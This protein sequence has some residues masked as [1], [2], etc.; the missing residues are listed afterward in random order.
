MNS[1]YNKC[2][3]FPNLYSCL[4]YLYPSNPIRTQTIYMP[5]SLCVGAFVLL[6]KA[7]NAIMYT[8]NKKLASWRFVDNRFFL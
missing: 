8:D 1:I 2:Y 3:F 5:F 6:G 7:S 4:S